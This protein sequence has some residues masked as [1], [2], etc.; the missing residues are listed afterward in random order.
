[1]PI[2]IYLSMDGYVEAERRCGAI[3]TRIYGNCPFLFDCEHQK[4]WIT[5]NGEQVEENYYSFELLS[6]KILI[7]RDF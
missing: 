2:Y 5:Y 3:P 7:F 1:M 4:L 6:N